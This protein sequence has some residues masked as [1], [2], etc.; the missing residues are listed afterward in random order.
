MGLLSKVCFDIEN[1]ARKTLAYIMGGVLALIGIYMAHRRIRALERQVQIGQEQLQVAQEGQITE[2][3]TRAIEQLGSDKMA[4][5]LGGIYALERIA[6]D[7]DKDYW[8]IME[9]LTAYVRER[10]AWKERPEILSPHKE[11]LSLPVPK[12]EIKPSTDIQAV[13]TVLGRRKYWYGQGETERLNLRETDLRGAS[14]EKLHFEGADLGEAH[15]EG[16]DLDEAY[17]EGVDLRDSHLNKANLCGA[18][19][20]GAFLTEAI[21]EGGFLQRARL[22]GADLVEANLKGANL[23]DATGITREQLDWA[24]TDEETIL[25]DYLQKQ[26]PVAKEPEGNDE[27]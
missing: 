19:L 13:L 9:T 24:S 3:F 7:S 5:R 1:E 25:P 2:R 15:L 14:L 21:L 27:E 20:E 10:A 8:P 11:G 23:R 16:A 12:P 6:N 22:K 17:L 18:S 26:P 4:I